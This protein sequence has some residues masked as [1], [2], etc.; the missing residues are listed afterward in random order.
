MVADEEMLDVDAQIGRADTK[1]L[2]GK[3]KG[4]CLTGLRHKHRRLLYAF[5]TPSI[6]P[7][8]SI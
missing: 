5:M 3:G 1:M 6:S 2:K 7:T 4:K 8:P